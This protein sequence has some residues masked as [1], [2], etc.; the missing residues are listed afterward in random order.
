M[1][2]ALHWFRRD[3]RT[4][5]NPAL[6]AAG[7]QAVRVFVRDPHF[8]AIGSPRRDYLDAALAPLAATVVSGDPARELLALAR[9]HSAETVYCT[10]DAT[11]YARRRDE[12]VAQVLARDG[13]D[14]V[15]V[16]S[17]YAIPPGE[18]RNQAGSGF[19][20]F[21]PFSKA[22]F[23]HGWAPVAGPVPE[24]PAVR[25]WRAFRDAGLADYRQRRDTAAVPGTSRLS[26]A[27]HFGTIHPR[28]V[29]AEV[30]DPATDPFARQIAWREFCADVLWH[31]PHAAW[32][33]LDERFDTEMEY[34]D[35]AD[36]FQAWT[37]GRTGYPFVD[38]GMRQLQAEGWMHNRLRMVTASFLVKDLH[39]PWQWGAKWFMHHL[40]DADVANNQLGWQWVAGCGTDA[41]P[42]FR[43]FNP[44]TQGRRFD[45]DGVY[46]R[47][48]VPELAE[49]D[50]PHEPGLFAP[51]YP[52]PIVD[53]GRER[54]VALARFQALPPARGRAR[55]GASGRR[56]P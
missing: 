55:G 42:Y 4:F 32:A 19:R 16:D 22:W 13:I 6:D 27:L 33:S 44:T 26:A 1:P 14:L 7:P 17:P 2:R 46:I 31:Q 35:D 45:P 23:A 29:L 21:T 20:V 9:A 50:D 43:I 30:P 52:A 53:H 8:A 47:R 41:A 38:A 39:L 5:D 56:S 34:S 11:P 18:V 48:Y 36:H 40:V 15:V 24:T 37:Q 51:D 54:E 49:V 12:H 25:Q 10:G 28:T 3:L